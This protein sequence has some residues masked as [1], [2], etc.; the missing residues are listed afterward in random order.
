MITNLIQKAKHVQSKKE[1][2]QLLSSQ[3]VEMQHSI[4]KNAISNLNA[5][6]E[7]DIRSND[8]S[9]ALYK[10]SHVVL[11]EDALHVIERVLLKQ[12]VLV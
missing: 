5:E 8:T 11:L 7:C 6:I 12:R 10:M 4:V 2:Q 9:I 3:S 1:L